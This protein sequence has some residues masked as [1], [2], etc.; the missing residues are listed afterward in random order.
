MPSSP[1]PHTIACFSS[2]L[3]SRESKKERK[4]KKYAREN[5]RRR[6]SYFG[7]KE[8]RRALLDNL[9]G[10][11][12]DCCHRYGLSMGDLP[13]VETFCDALEEIK[14]IGSFPKL[15]KS[16]LAEMEKM[17]AVDIPKLLERASKSKA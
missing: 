3:S 8:K 12:R 2:L 9:K 17:F 15:D 13:R 5:H 4:K 10:E 7:K 6:T 14:D 16:Q 11:F 1:S